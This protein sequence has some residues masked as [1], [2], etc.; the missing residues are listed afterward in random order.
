MTD[1]FGVDDSSKSLKPVLSDPLVRAAKKREG[2]MVPVS[3]LPLLDTSPFG[4]WPDEVCRL[5]DPTIETGLHRTVAE[6]DWVR[7]AMTGLRLHFGSHQIPHP[8]KADTGGEDSLFTC[9]D[10][11]AMGVADGVGEW[12]LRFKLNPRAFADEMMDGACATAVRAWREN[13]AMSPRDRA[14]LALSE[15]F[16]L[17]KSFGSATALVACLDA[18]GSE[19]GVANLGDSGLRLIRR[20]HVVGMASALPTGPMQ[21]MAR[22]VDQQHSFN[23][24]YQLARLPLPSD[25]PR[26]IAEGKRALVRAVQNFPASKQDMPKDADRY[27][28]PIQEGD[29]IVIGTDGVFD[30]L[31]DRELTQLG[32]AAVSPFEARQGLDLETGR[33]SGEGSTSPK[34]IAAAIAQAAFYR[35]KDESAKTPFTANAKEAGL[36]HVGGKMDD[37]TVVAA[38][39]VRTC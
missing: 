27:V 10:Y 4:D 9:P 35:S 13:E 34:N 38:W 25:F 6:E 18:A 5:L 30:N 20:Q 22:T 32:G 33:L 16:D 3:S 14:A 8:R 19:L 28:F 37:I 29:L 11:S 15:G 2:R 23:C 31:H 21:I 12:A 36:I 26:L 39:V 17:S 24:P 7:P 1:C